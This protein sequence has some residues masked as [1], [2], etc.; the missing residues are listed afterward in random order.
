MVTKTGNSFSF[1]EVRLGVG[2]EKARIFLKENPK[3]FGEI[4]K[5]IKEKVKE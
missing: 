1:G 5:A 3:V 2:R 4:L